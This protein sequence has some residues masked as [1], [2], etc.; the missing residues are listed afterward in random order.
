MWVVKRAN[1]N[2]LKQ[3]RNSGTKIFLD[4]VD[5]WPQGRRNNPNDS[6]EI[7]LGIVKDLIDEIAP[8]AVIFPNYAMWSDMRASFPSTPSTFIY[9]HFRPQY[10]LPVPE[11][12]LIQSDTPIVAYEGGDYLGHWRSLLK[13]TCSSIG[14]LFIE[15]PKDLRQASAIVSARGDQHF[16]F[17]NANYKSNVK[18]ANAIGA[19]VPFVCHVSERAAQETDPGSFL[20]FSNPANLRACLET[21][22]YDDDFR[23]FNKIQMDKKRELYTLESVAQQVEEFTSLVFSSDLSE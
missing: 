13:D 6:P 19:R 4:V 3:A 1:D 18:A 5:L 12:T 16:T 22:L 17:L 20:F 21:A 2:V 7:S 8:H 15:N 9:H 23:Q 11:E 14:A 10:N